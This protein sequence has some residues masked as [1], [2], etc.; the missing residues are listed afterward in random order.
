MHFC[1]VCKNIQIKGMQKRCSLC[2]SLK[3]CLDCKIDLKNKNSRHLKCSE[4]RK[5]KKKRICKSCNKKYIGKYNN[6]STCKASIDRKR[7]LK[8]P[9]GSKL[10]ASIE[11]KRRA[12]IKNAIPKWSNL[13]EIKEF[14]INCPEGFEVD[15][16]I[17]INNNYVCGLHVQNNLQYLKAEQNH[18]KSNK[19]DFTY[20]NE[21][22]KKEVTNE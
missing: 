13:Q 5:P 3:K 12:K 10:L 4:C 22:W 19:F 8:K 6:C 11:S 15:H 14:Y 21:T 1:I 16:I 2:Q 18:F 9:H 17:P 7:L 20:N